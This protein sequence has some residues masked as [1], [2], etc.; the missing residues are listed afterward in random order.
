MSNCKCVITLIGG[1]A[2]GFA[3]L[4][5]ADM[6]ERKMDSVCF[7]AQPLNEVIAEKDTE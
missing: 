5:G 7:N 1:M 6:Y 2:L 3:I 4:I